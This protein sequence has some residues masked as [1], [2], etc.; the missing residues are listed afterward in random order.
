MQKK[1]VVCVVVALSL[2]G[3][4]SNQVEVGHPL[5]Q[6]SFEGHQRVSVLWVGVVER[7]NE[8]GWTS[9][10]MNCDDHAQDLT[11]ERSLCALSL[12]IVLFRK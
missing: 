7:R 1:T 3:Y 5:A 9:A 8:F 2:E 10:T 11:L 6:W 4:R 12:F